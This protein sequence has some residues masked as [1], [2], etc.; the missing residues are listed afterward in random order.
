[1]L[2]YT[3]QK[4]TR[5][6]PYVWHNFPKWREVTSKFSDRS[7]CLK[8]K[9]FFPLLL[10]YKCIYMLI[11]ICILRQFGAFLRPPYLYSKSLFSHYYTYTQQLFYN[12]NK[13]GIGR[14]D[15]VYYKEKY[16]GISPALLVRTIF[17]VLQ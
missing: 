5:H 9:P 3:L 2:L 7:T 15:C 14:G 11:Y 4:I 17:F 10:L 6:A 8:I 1:M 13:G 12:R 16:R